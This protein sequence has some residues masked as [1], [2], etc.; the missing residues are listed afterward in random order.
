MVEIIEKFA[1]ALLLVIPLIW[2]VIWFY[3]KQSGLSSKSGKGL[4]KVMTNLPLGPKKAISVVSI[5]GEYLVLGITNEQISYLTK[6]EDKDIVNKLESSMD[7]DEE[8][9]FRKF[10]GGLNKPGAINFAGKFRLKKKDRRSEDL[11]L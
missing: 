9:G 1:G 11:E 7:S 4:M 5:G 6:I 2:L 3:S 10:L 8:H